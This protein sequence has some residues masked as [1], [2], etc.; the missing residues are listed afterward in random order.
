MAKRVS[1]AWLLDQVDKLVECEE[2]VGLTESMEKLALQL[3]LSWRD[4]RAESERLRGIVKNLR[5]ACNESL[6][7][8]DMI[9][10]SPLEAACKYGPDWTPPDDND[11]LEL[12][13]LLAEAAEAAKP[14]GEA[15]P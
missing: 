7:F 3:G 9:A 14:E 2:K 5:H 10:L 12:R 1:V 15:K 13:Q 8:Y 6:R 11:A 4:E